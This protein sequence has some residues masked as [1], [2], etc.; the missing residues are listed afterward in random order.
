MESARIT[1]M[2]I[3]YTAV[4]APVCVCVRARVCKVICTFVC[5]LIYLFSFVCRRK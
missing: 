1:R 2:Q 3:V 4:R 5:L